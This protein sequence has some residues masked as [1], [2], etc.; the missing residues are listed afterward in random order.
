MEEMIMADAIA[1]LTWWLIA[2][3]SINVAVI[4]G[5][6]AIMEGRKQRM[7][8]TTSGAIIAALEQHVKRLRKTLQRQA[9]SICDS[10]D[11]TPVANK[12]ELKRIVSE[13]REMAD[14]MTDVAP[15]VGNR[16]SYHALILSTIDWLE[17]AKG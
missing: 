5:R 15:G 17:K 6:R 10:P 2:C 13:L 3:F 11:E 9:D 4:Y 14:N 8:S 1:D 16:S 7:R 12:E